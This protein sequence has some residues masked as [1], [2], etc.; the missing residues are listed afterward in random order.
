MFSVKNKVALV[1][2][3]SRGIGLDI[4]RG[5]LEN[6]AAK[7]YISS[8]SEAACKEAVSDLQSS[9]KSDGKAVA[10]ACNFSDHKDVKRLFNFISEDSSGVLNIVIANAGT[11]WGAPLEKHPP[12]AFD[13]V[14]G[15]N[16]KGVFMTI[17]GA[18]GMLEHSGS[19]EDPSRVV[20]VGSIAGLSVGSLGSAGTY[21]YFASKAA[22]HHLAKSLGVEL[23]PRNITV[24]AIAPGFIKTKMSDGLIRLLGEDNISEVNPRGRMALPKDIEASIIYL[25]SSAG[26][27]IN[28][29]ILPIDGGMHL[30]SKL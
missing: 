25:C 1:T 23:G 17:Q 18:A 13:K 7:V 20:I 12:E 21:G 15:L 8:R 27:Y 19:A 10:I 24:N 29:I 2:G 14:F 22:V 26:S 9:L 4:A 28:G 30:V 3:G 11:T 16:V 6:G 5:L